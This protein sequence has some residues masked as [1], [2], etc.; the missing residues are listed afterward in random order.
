MHC[1]LTKLGAAR[2]DGI[3]VAAGQVVEYLEGKSGPRR[4]AM[5]P[6]T[7][8]RS[9]DHSPAAYYAD[10]AESPGV[11]RT[12]GGAGTS[13]HG[14]VDADHLRALLQGNDPVTGTS[15]IAAA[16]SAQRAHRR[17]GV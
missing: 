16:G 5:R 15:L 1:S 14:E 12:T 8:E 10:S 11:W 9:P 13:V 3:A 6:G 17:D 7:A 4:G 2:S